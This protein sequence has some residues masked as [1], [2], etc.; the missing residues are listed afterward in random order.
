MSNVTGWNEFVDGEI[1][2]S[3]WTLY[4]VSWANH[5][6]LALWLTLNAVIIMKTKNPVLGFF[7][8]MLAFLIFQPEF[9]TLGGTVVILVLVIEIA[10]ALYKIFF[11]R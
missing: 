4:Q 11:G 9:S 8:G 7:L 1:I 5:F 2:K 3:V 6:I 10:L